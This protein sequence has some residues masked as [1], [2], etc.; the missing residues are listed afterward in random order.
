MIPSDL[1]IEQIEAA[2]MPLPKGICNRERKL[3]YC[4]VTEVEISD[5]EGA[6]KIGRPEGRYVTVETEKSYEIGNPAFEEI[7]AELSKELAKMLKGRKKVLVIGIGNAAITPD[8]LGAKAVERI[9]ITRP[10][11]DLPKGYSIVSAVASPV[12]GASGVESYE[13]ARGLVREVRPEAVVLIDAL[14]T[15]N[16]ARLCKTVQLANVGLA[17]G[18]GVGN[19]RPALDEQSLG[20]PVISVGMPTVVDCRALLY[21]VLGEDWEAYADGLHPYEESL[22][23]VPRQMELATD[24]G[25]RII[26]FALNKALHGDLD[27]QEILRYLY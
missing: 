21:H 14:A 4:N 11:E 5:R 3:K 18:G 2:K 12:F 22:I 7:A 17:P 9:M 16:L 24:M 26:A 1:M 27:T 23:A 20:C 8:S 19:T 10:L 6:E 13:L 25:A 15:G